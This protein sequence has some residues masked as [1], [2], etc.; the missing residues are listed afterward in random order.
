VDTPG[1]REHFL[2]MASP[3]R[4]L[5][6]EDRLAAVSEARWASGETRGVGKRVLEP[7]SGA[8]FR[9]IRELAESEIASPSRARGLWIREIVLE[10]PAP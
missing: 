10:N 9:E 7:T 8:D 2:V 6:V 3:A 1:G 5:K 4:L